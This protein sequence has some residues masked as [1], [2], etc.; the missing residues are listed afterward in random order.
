[1]E[2]TGDVF[3]GEIVSLRDCLVQVTRASEKRGTR[4]D[5][6]TSSL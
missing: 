6:D 4:S 1:M 5:S 2:A 3:R